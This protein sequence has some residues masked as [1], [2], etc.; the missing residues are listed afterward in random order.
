MP[1]LLRFLAIVAL[2]CGVVY[3][4]LFALANFVKPKQREITISV[5]P[6]KF[7]KNR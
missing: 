4:G 7:F 2:V 3:V 6:E 5:P 1:S